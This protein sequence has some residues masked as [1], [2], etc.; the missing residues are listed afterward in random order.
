[1]DLVASLK[2]QY[3]VSRIWYGAATKRGIHEQSHGKIKPD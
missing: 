3:T 2:T 1:M